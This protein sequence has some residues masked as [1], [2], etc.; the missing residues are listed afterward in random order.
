MKE[1]SFSRNVSPKLLDRLAILGKDSPDT[2]PNYSHI[3]KNESVMIPVP[4]VFRAICP[5]WFRAD[6]W[7]RTMLLGMVDD[8]IE[9]NEER[10]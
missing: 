6:K 9:A 2:L 10:R 3:R 5:P 8:L 1:F 7:Q 4:S